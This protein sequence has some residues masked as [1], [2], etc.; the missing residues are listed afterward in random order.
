M[1]EGEHSSS[2]HCHLP[3]VAMEVED[4]GGLSHAVSHSL[5]SHVFS[6]GSEG[7]CFKSAL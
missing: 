1:S 5:K 7:M 3:M 4:R 2:L 6:T